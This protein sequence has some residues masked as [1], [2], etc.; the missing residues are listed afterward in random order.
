[1]ALKPG[2]YELFDDI[3]YFGNSAMERG[4][5]VSIASSATGVGEAM[6]SSIMIA[7]YNTVALVNNSGA[8]PLGILMT[9]MVNIDQSRQHLNQYKSEAQVGDKVLVLKKGWVVTNWIAPGSASG[10][11]IAGA[12]GYLVSSGLISSD[13][14]LAASG[15]PVVGKFLTNK[16]SDGYAKFQ[17]EL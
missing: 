5:I 12:P 11:L 10:A 1:M 8:R 15:N 6:D 17:V 2:R 7:E 16:D 4:G 13:T 9:D 3:S 14:R